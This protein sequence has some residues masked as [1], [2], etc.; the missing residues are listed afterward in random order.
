[1]LTLSAVSSDPFPKGH[2]TYGGDVGGLRGARV[3]RQAPEE[4]CVLGGSGCPAGILVGDHRRCRRRIDRRRAPIAAE[5][6]SVL[7]ALPWFAFGVASCV[8]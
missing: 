4:A 7:L 8:Q 5:G 1:M 2:R 3:S 6:R